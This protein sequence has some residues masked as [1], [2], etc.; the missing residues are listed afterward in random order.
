MGPDE[1]A[2]I[3]DDTGFDMDGGYD[4]GG[5]SFGSETDFKRGGG[6]GGAPA[7][8][9]T[10]SS[11]NMASEPG[12]DVEEDS[13]IG[14]GSP[15]SASTIEV[16]TNIES[17]RDVEVAVE[18][19]GS[20]S[21]CNCLPDSAAAVPGLG[22][23]PLGNQLRPVPRKT[24]TSKSTKTSTKSRSRTKV[25]ASGIKMDCKDDYRHLY[26]MIFQHAG[27]R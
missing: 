18:S 16:R 17:S 24:R 1:Q 13:S 15:E 20:T 25:K 14:A 21:E 10:S 22:P 9:G 7:S 26:E 11:D 27:R 5:G 4:M 19:E 3:G 6:G 12:S 23:I 2:G 8:S